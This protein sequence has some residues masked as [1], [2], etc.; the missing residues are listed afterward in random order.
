MA[1]FTYGKTFTKKSSRGK[2]KKGTRI[3]YKYN[4]RGRRV[5]AVK[6]RRR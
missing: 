4:S 3:R 1:R 2:F 6:A 5:G